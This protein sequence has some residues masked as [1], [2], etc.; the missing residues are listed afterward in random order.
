[1]L[2]SR[3]VSAFTRPGKYHVR[4]VVLLVEV[5]TAFLMFCTESNN[6]KCKSKHGEDYHQYLICTHKHHPPST[7]LGSGDGARPSTASNAM[8]GTHCVVL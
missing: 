2:D 7:R 3:R 6:V 4:E 5:R 8:R 1:M